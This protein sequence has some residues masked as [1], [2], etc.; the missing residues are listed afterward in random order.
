MYMFTHL[1]D[2]WLSLLICDS[3]CAVDALKATENLKVLQYAIKL[4]M[5]TCYFTLLL[6]LVVGGDIVYRSRNQFENFDVICYRFYL[7]KSGDVTFMDPLMQILLHSEQKGPS[8]WRLCEKHI[9]TICID[10]CDGKTRKSI[11]DILLKAIAMYFTY[12]FINFYSP[13]HEY[14]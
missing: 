7:P 11:K 10:Y 6:P 3:I 4:F 12:W 1:Y 14:L 2:E 9:V 8:L 5:R 13:A